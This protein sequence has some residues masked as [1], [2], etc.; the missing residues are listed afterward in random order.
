MLKG[1]F[2]V[3]KRADMDD[4]EFRRHWRQIQGPRRRSL[5]SRTLL[6]T[7]KAEFHCR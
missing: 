6:A 5:I 2:L 4:Q 7:A 3:H 1:V